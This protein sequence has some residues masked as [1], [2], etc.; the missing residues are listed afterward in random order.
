MCSDP[1]PS[2]NLRNRH[3][4][5]GRDFMKFIALTASFKMDLSSGLIFFDAK[6]SLCITLCVHR[7]SGFFCHMCAMRPLMRLVIDAVVSVH[8]LI[9]NFQLISSSEKNELTMLK[10]SSPVVL[11]SSV[12]QK[13][14]CS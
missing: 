3:A 6:A 12:L 1:M 4:F 2:H 11:P 13:S 14:M 9:Q 7:V 5:S 10:I 8:T